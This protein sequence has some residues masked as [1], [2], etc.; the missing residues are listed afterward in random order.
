MRFFDVTDDRDHLSKDVT[1][2]RNVERRYGSS[3]L[4]MIV[5]TCVARRQRASVHSISDW[6][7]DEEVCGE[8]SVESPAGTRGTLDPNRRR[9]VTGGSGEAAPSVHTYSPRA[10][11]PGP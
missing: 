11:L 4:R 9:H 5:I 7:A 8:W 6:D 3:T 10:K 2:D 1:D